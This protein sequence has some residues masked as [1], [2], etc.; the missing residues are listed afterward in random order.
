MHYLS[1]YFATLN[2]LAAQ[3]AGLA[4]ENIKYLGLKL[5]VSV[6][7]PPPPELLEPV[8]MEATERESSSLDVFICSIFI[9]IETTGSG[10][11]S[12]NSIPPLLFTGQAPPISAP[13]TVVEANDSPVP[14]SDSFEKA[15]R[16]NIK[17]DEKSKKNPLF[18]TLVQSYFV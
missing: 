2:K 16:N 17:I 6:P 3:L 7:P 4:I 5:S 11:V 10:T 14:D 8:R 13:P 15:K 18:T 1:F 12:S 9:S